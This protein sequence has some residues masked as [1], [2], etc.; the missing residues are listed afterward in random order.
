MNKRDILK[1]ACT[2]VASAAV[3]TLTSMMI[4]SN[5]IPS[6]VKEKAALAIGGFILSDMIACKASDHVEKTI[7][8]AFGIFDN[9]KQNLTNQNEIIVEEGDDDGRAAN[10]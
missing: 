5:A 9:L 2:F 7:D 1:T 8:D 10:A 3:G 6:N 4:K